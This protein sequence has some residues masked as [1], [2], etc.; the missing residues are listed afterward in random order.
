[1]NTTTFQTDTGV[2]RHYVL[3]LAE[4]G[5]EVSVVHVLYLND[6]PIVTLHEHVDGDVAAVVR[7]VRPTGDVERR[8]STVWT[9]ADDTEDITV[10]IE[11]AAL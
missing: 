2:R 8:V 7:D 11:R 3:R 5:D 6:T 9:T 4:D 1:M 10:R